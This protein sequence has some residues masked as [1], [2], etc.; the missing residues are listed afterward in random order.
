MFRLFL[1]HWVQVINYSVVCPI[2]SSFN[3][4]RCLSTNSFCMWTLCSLLFTL[5][6]MVLVLVAIDLSSLS[7]TSPFYAL[8][9]VISLYLLILLNS[10]YGFHSSPACSF[11]LA[12]I[13]I[14][15]VSHFNLCS[16]F[17]VVCFYL[18]RNRSFDDYDAFLYALHS[19]ELECLTHN[20]MS[21]CFRWSLASVDIL[22]S[23]LRYTETSFLWFD[24]VD[25]FELFLK[26]PTSVR[27]SSIL[28]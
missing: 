6:R 8:V 14:S 9:I 23:A 27:S 5:Y 2:A 4:L 22:D 24:G 1:Y 15:P 12:L 20:F 28:Y 11:V 10:W 16:S 21:M 19:R 3:S 26:M 17:V 25:F 13:L 7:F 18:N